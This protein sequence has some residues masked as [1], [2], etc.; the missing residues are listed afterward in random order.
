MP[1]NTVFDHGCVQRPLPNAYLS[2]EAT[3]AEGHLTT[4]RLTRLPAGTAGE[5]MEDI[6][7]TIANCQWH[8]ED[9]ENQ[10]AAVTG[11]SGHDHGYLVERQN[12]KTKSG[13]PWPNQPGLTMQVVGDYL[14]MVESNYPSMDEAFAVAE[15]VSDL[16]ASNVRANG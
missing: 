15:R 14:V 4:I 13:V 7:R 11:W 8:R 5:A 16:V 10:W 9:G 6:Q 1:I 2:N 12:T 3:D